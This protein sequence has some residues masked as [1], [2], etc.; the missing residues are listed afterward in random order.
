[1]I[2]E[3]REDNNVDIV[4]T[5]IPHLYSLWRGT[6]K[7]RIRSLYRRFII[8]QIRVQSQAIHQE[9]QPSKIKLLIYL[10]QVSL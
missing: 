5:L 6:L 4:T 2:L 9:E 1:M 10:P 7:N 8:F 3:S